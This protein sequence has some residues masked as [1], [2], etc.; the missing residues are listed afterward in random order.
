MSSWADIRVDDRLSLLLRRIVKR[1]GQ[2]I[3]K[4]SMD[5][6]LVFLQ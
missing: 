4:K 1:Y 6:E 5:N 2:F 3:A